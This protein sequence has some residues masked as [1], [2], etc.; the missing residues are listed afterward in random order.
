MSPC[1]EVGDVKLRTKSVEFA[2]PQAAEAAELEIAA[3]CERSHAPL[4]ARAELARD[5]RATDL[6]ELSVGSERPARARHVRLPVIL[7]VATGLST[8][9][10]GV[11]H[12]LP[13]PFGSE[14]WQLLAADWVVGLGYMAM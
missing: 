12:W 14:A 13:I 1:L 9:W 10:V 4:P 5:E 6:L 8:F 7:F 11:N 2:T 3:P